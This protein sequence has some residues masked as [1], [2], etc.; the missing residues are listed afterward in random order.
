[1][2]GI[3]ECDPLCLTP[4]SP[5]S[6]LQSP[7]GQLSFCEDIYLEEEQRLS[8]KVI[9]LFIKIDFQPHSSERIER[10]ELWWREG[11][12]SWGGVSY[13]GGGCM[14]IFFGL[15]P[16]NAITPADLQLYPTVAGAVVPIYNLNGVTDLV[17]SLEPREGRLGF[18][19]S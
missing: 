4:F 14:V 12:G 13:A 7:L 19:T 2:E 17:L 10:S 3:Y 5:A 8:R 11:F 9:I 16:G 15:P 6:G 1:M 18:C